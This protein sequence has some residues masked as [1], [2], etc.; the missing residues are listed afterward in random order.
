MIRFGII[1]DTDPAKGLARVKFPEDEITS[2]WLPVLVPGSTGNKYFHTFDTNEPV[3]CLMDIN[4]ENGVILGAIYGEV[5]APD[6]GGADLARIV[7]S[8]GTEMQY[9]RAASEM[10]VK[11]G[12]TEFKITPAGYSIKRASETLYAII[13]DFI[14]AITTMTHI[15]AA[16]GSP[17]TPPD[18]ATLATLSALQTR[19]S[20]LLQ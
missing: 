7:F 10:S 8:D 18:P 3:V 9:D 2:F 4:L 6:G 17:T 13:N 15:S 5:N 20:T 14:T 16:P 11:I 12:T 19:V 1:C